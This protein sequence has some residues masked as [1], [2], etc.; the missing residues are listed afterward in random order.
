[1]HCR[2]HAAQGRDVGPCGSLESQP[3]RAFMSVFANVVCV[4][5]VASGWRE[6]AHMTFLSLFHQL[7]SPPSLPT[8]AALVLAELPLSGLQLGQWW[9]DS[10]LKW[11]WPGLVVQ[12]LFTL[13]L[14]PMGRPAWD[15]V[16]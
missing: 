3:E 16:S 11:D 9:V 14:L 4:V 12:T 6:E 1:M 10:D 7:T 8:L 15:F 5:C 2:T 13:T